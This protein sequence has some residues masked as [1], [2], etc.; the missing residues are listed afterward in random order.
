MKT[1]NENQ[2]VGSVDELEQRLFPSDLHRSYN[3]DLMRRARRM[4]SLAKEAADLRRLGLNM[5]AEKKETQI[6]E[7]AATG[8]TPR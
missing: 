5:E 4:N 3:N 6:A 8:N 2:I 7:L 1:E